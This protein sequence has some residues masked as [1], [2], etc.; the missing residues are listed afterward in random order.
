MLINMRFLGRAEATTSRG[1]R[2]QMKTF[3]MFPSSLPPS[4]VLYFFPDFC[5]FS[6]LFAE[7]DF[8]AAAHRCVLSSL[9]KAV[10]R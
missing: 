4:H 1:V 9:G 7:L 2:G 3:F 10:A 5:S 6:C 8:P